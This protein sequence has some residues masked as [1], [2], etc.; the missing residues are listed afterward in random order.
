MFFHKTE[1]VH[2]QRD[3]TMKQ[4]M[5]AGSAVLGLFLFAVKR[6]YYSERFILGYGDQGRMALWHINCDVHFGESSFH[7]RAKAHGFS[8][9]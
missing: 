4:P 5:G 2:G 8:R 1:R 7:I 6:W 3:I 9:R